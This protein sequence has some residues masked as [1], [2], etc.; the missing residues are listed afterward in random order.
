MSICL[1]YCP[2]K[3]GPRIFFTSP[4][5][6]TYYNY[7]YGSMQGLALADDAVNRGCRDVYLQTVMRF[8]RS[9][10][11]LRADA[12]FDVRPIAIAV[13]MQPD[14][15]QRRP[16]GLFGI[17]AQARTP[18]SAGP[19]S[20]KHPLSF[21]GS[22][23]CCCWRRKTGERRAAWRERW[24]N[25]P[26]PVK[27]FKIKSASGS[28]VL[29]PLFPS[30]FPVV[31]SECHALGTDEENDAIKYLLYLWWMFSHSIVHLCVF[32]SSKSYTKTSIKKFKKLNRL[33]E[34]K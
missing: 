17:R 27:T 26:I 24:S 33:Y 9:K 18:P 20:Y 21:A 34:N 11:T 23:G 25:V 28:T 3:L 14:S 6:E 16:R 8:F 31:F 22:H 5:V 7:E 12:F 19:V 10:P 13:W 4:T 30:I 2:S 32:H 15:I 29:I 1:H